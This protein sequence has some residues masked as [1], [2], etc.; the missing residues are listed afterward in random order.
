MPKIVHI[1]HLLL[2]MSRRLIEVHDTP[3]S[4]FPC[5]GQLSRDAIVSFRLPIEAL[6]A[7]VAPRI[8]ETLRDM[9][10]ILLYEV[11]GYISKDK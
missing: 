8:E 11:S 3:V 5:P 7:D 9:Y 1:H 6:S 4:I 2:R 10:E